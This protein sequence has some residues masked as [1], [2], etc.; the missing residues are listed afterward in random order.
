MRLST[1]TKHN[2]S[3]E[4]VVEAV[5]PFHDDTWRRALKGEKE[6]KFSDIKRP[7]SSSFT[8]SCCVICWCAAWLLWCFCMSTAAS[9]SARLNKP[10]FRPENISPWKTKFRWKIKNLKLFFFFLFPSSANFSWKK[11]YF[12]DFYAK[13]KNENLCWWSGEDIDLSCRRG[14]LARSRR[15]VFK[16][17]VDFKF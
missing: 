12:G 10:S 9:A 7:I 5:H 16:S 1:I 6:H 13:D 15:I 11:T 17:N 4:V 14:G 3:P 8:L 2:F